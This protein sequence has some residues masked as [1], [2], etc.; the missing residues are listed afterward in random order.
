LPE[1]RQ[2]DNESVIPDIL[3]ELKPKTDPLD[4]N[5]QLQITTADTAVYIGITEAVRIRI[6]SIA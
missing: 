1:I 2:N 3:L 5:M 6:T 4:C